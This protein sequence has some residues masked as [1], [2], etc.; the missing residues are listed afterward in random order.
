M[1]RKRLAI[2]ILLIALYLVAAH[3]G[4]LIER[5]IVFVSSREGALRISLRHFQ[6]PNEW[7]ITPEFFKMFLGSVTRGKSGAFASPWLYAGLLTS[8]FLLN[9]MLFVRI[10]DTAPRKIRTP[11]IQGAG[12]D[13]ILRYALIAERL[14]RCSMDGRILEIGSSV[15]GVAAF[16]DK[17]AIVGLD[18]RPIDVNTLPQNLMMVRASGISAPFSDGSFDYVVCVDVIEHIMPA[19]RDRLIEEALRLTRNTLFIT[20]PMGNKTARAERLLYFLLAPFYR[21]FHKDLSFLRE[22]IE[23]GL[24]LKEELLRAIARS[25]PDAQLCMSRNVNLW[26]WILCMF[27][28][29]FLRRITKRTGIGW[30]CSFVSTFVHLLSVGPQ[31]RLLLSVSK[32]RSPGE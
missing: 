23:N 9:I 32:L 30:L 14:S 16:L 7:V 12:I 5:G 3:S 13:F 26:V 10:T 2:G 11:N 18:H 25:A 28:D 8:Y 21:I 1:L 22:H 31:Y 4:P 20:T 17:H 6:Q 24:P 19:D 27:L 29:P 15:S